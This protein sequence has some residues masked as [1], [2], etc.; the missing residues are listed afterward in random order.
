MC[1]ICGKLNLGN[2]SPPVSEA[3]LRCMLNSIGH[4]GP[5]EDGIYRSGPVG[6]GHRRLKIIDLHS[7]QQPMSNED[8]SIWVIYNGE[9]YNYKEL[10]AGLIQ[11]GHK[12][13]TASDTETI[14][15]L[16]EE[17]GA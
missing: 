1:G 11:K 13:K 2:D 3:N 7:G 9:V 16:F 10:R 17:F 8:N 4:R 15:H 6:L 12:F 5:D 14:V